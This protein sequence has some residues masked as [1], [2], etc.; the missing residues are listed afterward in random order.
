MMRRLTRFML[1]SILGWGVTACEGGLPEP[2]LR[3]SAPPLDTAFVPDL[4][5]AVAPD[6]PPVADFSFDS[7]SDKGLPPGDLTVD[8]VS[9]D[10]TV[11]LV[12]ADAMVDSV[13]PDAT[14]DV[15]LDVTVDQGIPAA[16]AHVDST[17][18]AFNP[19]LQGWAVQ[20]P[21]PVLSLG[22]MGSFDQT[23]LTEPY[24]MWD[25]NHYKM[26]YV[27]ASLEEGTVG[28]ATSVDG[29]NW[30]KEPTNPVLKVGPANTWDERGINGFSVL[31]EGT[32]YSMWYSA[33]GNASR[34]IGHAV[35]P[36]GITWTKYVANPIF[37]T[38][39]SGTWD[40][41]LDGCF[42]IKDGPTYHMWYTAMEKATEIRRVGYA[43][44]SDGMNWTKEAN[45]VLPTGAPG[46]WDEIYATWP[47]VIKEADGSFTMWYFGSGGSPFD[48]GIGWA[49]SLD[50]KNWTKEYQ[51]VLLGGS[52]G[53]WDAYLI[54]RPAVI[55]ESPSQLHMWYVGALGISPTG[56]QIGYATHQ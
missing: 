2:T 21:V 24:V 26:W 38:G 4:D 18:D 8:A 39:V 17:T 16:D 36:D 52:P 19:G 15:G 29:V 3:D 25:G 27:G 10:M 9:P 49:T 46:Q 40:E 33:R 14:V 44:S 55:R 20:S 5:S 47:S 31:K 12:S 11:D 42:V 32:G 6:L 37:V 56:A 45:A 48:T 22:S 1:V 51:P 23:Y 30:A 41:N 54:G 35:S 53:Q 34:S 28:L 43:S 50:G 13:S 7:S